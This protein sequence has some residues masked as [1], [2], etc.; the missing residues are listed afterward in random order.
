MNVCRHL[1]PWGIASKAGVR[2][3]PLAAFLLCAATLVVHSGYV[4]RSRAAVREGEGIAANRGAEKTSG[5][6]IKEVVPE[7]Y[8]A[9]YERWKAEY[10][11]TGAGREQWERYARDEEF[12][13]T[14]KVSP[15]LEQGGVVGGYRWNGAGKLVAATITL[16]SELEEGYLPPYYYPVTSALSSFDADEPQSISGEIRAATKM[17]HEFGHVNQAAVSDASTFRLQNRLLDSYVKIFKE[18]GYKQDDPRLAELVRRMGEQPSEIKR[19]R[20]Y[21]AEANALVY[22]E[23]RM[24]G[25]PGDRALFRRIRRLINEYAEDHLQ[26]FK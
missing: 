19:D 17:A 25:E 23:E 18:N 10:L 22:L 11:S 7:K 14:I 12:T 24:E 16:G 15:D 26:L 5:R 20:E 2:A 4:P 8:L 21:E 13:L 9:R 3:L 6:S 1:A